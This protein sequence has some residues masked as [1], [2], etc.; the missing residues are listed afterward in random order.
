MGRTE[1]N[2]L[3]LVPYIVVLYTGHNKCQQV[4][5]WLRGGACA[6]TVA[7][8]IYGKANVLDVLY[9]VDACSD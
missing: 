6:W 8:N 7:K 2:C 1:E 9:L 4:I 5:M 3:M